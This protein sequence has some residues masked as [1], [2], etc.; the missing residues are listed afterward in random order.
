MALYAHHLK[1]VLKYKMYLKIIR[2]S[3]GRFRF[4]NPIYGYKIHFFR[5]FFWSYFSFIHEPL[6]FIIQ[7][8]REVSMYYNH[9][10]SMARNIV[11]ILEFL[12]LKM[13]SAT[14]IPGGYFIPE[15]YLLRERSMGARIFINECGWAP[16]VFLLKT[17]ELQL[18]I[19]C[20]RNESNFT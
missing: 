20:L 13:S 7:E 17:R 14:S 15:M 8:Q 16:D 3:T 12:G 1:K 4:S 2:H 18:W 6:K 5:A 11:R 10:S 19:I 9:Y